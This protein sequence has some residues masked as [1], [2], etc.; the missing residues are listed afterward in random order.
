MYETLAK[1]WVLEQIRMLDTL[2]A[3]D[4]KDLNLG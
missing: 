1:N 4:N 3:F 2:K